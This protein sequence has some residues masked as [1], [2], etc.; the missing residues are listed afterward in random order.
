VLVRLTQK[1]AKKIKVVPATAMPLHDNPFL[2][3][4]AHLF[5]VSRWQCIMLTNSRSLYSIVMP[6]AGITSKESFFQFS[7]KWLHQYMVTDNTA[8]LFDAHITPD[9]DTVTF[10]KAGDRRVL[11]S[12]NDLIYHARLGLLESGYPPTMVMSRLNDMPMSML[13]M[14]RPRG[15]LL[16]LDD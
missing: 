13:K 16:A 11:G 2:D 7:L 1:L 6:G 12:V 4:T 15:A 14:C 3:W 8:H 9:I 5:M 10:C